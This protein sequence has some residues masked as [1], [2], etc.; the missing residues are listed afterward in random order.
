MIGDAQ[1]VISIYIS[2]FDLSL[3]TSLTCALHLKFEP[4]WKK[5]KRP[6]YVPVKH[7]NSNKA[8]AHTI[9]LS[10]NCLIILLKHRTF[11]Y[12]LIT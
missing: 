1:I 3:G 8:T 5:Y 10:F 2:W 12:G 9:F 4:T 11:F 6:R 7:L